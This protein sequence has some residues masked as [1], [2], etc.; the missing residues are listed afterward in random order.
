MKTVFL[1]RFETTEEKPGD[2]EDR[3]KNFPKTKAR[4]EQ[5]VG[6]E[7]EQNV[8]ELWGR[9]N[10]VTCNWSTKEGAA[11]EILVRSFPVFVTDTKTLFQKWRP[12]RAE[13]N[14]NQE[15]ITTET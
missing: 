15:Q 13:L 6:G 14:R 2:L 10:A 8:D 5:Q 7:K 3:S 12:L 11:E 4:R 1:G 9:R